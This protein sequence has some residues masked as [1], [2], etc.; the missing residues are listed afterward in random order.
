M[1]KKRKRGSG[2][3]GVV[4][5]LI[6]GVVAAGYFIRDCLPSFGGGKGPGAG[7]A[8][9]TEKSEKKTD[10]DKNTVSIV[11]KGEQCSLAGADAMDCA[12]LC[13][14]L[15][16]QHAP[17]T[18]VEIDTTVGTQATVDGFKSCLETGGFRNIVARSN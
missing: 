13:E 6:A 9:S 11:V 7:G 16:G 8:E 1:V 17:D 15:K 14:Q 2:R 5:L 10:A 18:R 3:M 4:A 12:A